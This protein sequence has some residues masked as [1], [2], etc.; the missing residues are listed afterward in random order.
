M[1]NIKYSKFKN[2]NNKF[3]LILNKMKSQKLKN[4][5]KM[6]KTFKKKFSDFKT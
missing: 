4:L 3:K 1:K 6:M 2:N 5:M